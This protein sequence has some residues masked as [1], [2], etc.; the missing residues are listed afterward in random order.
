MPP[1]AK[2][3]RASPGKSPK[4]ASKPG[5][6]SH[7]AHGHDN[8][9]V[10]AE[11]VDVSRSTPMHSQAEMSRK[12]S[13]IDCSVS[14]IKTAILSEDPEWKFNTTFW[15]TILCGHPAHEFRVLQNQTLAFW[16][17]K[18][19]KWQEMGQWNPALVPAC[20]DGKGIG[21]LLG[22]QNN[23]ISDFL[24]LF[25]PEA[26]KR[27]RQ[28]GDTENNR[29]YAQVNVAEVMITGV[30]LSRLIPSRHKLRYAFGVVDL[31]DDRTLDVEQFAAFIR[32]FIRGLGAAF[33][34]AG[35]ADV[36]P[37]EASIVTIANRLY[38]RISLIAAEKLKDLH[39][40][41]DANTKAQLADAIRAQQA[42][43]DSGK[44]PKNGGKSG[45]PRRQLLKFGTLQDWCFRVYKDPLALPYA[46]AI[47]RFCP[48]RYG[49]IL[50]GT[51][52]CDSLADWYLSHKEPVVEPREYAA[53]TEIGQTL[54]RSDVII[55]REVFRYCSFRGRFALCRGDVERHIDTSMTDSLWDSIEAGLKQVAEDM[56]SCVKPEF[57]DFLRKLSPSADSRHLRMFEVWCQQYDDLAVKEKLVKAAQNAAD[58]FLENDLKPVWPE[59]EVHQAHVL[60]EAVDRSGNGIVSAD[61]IEKGLGVDR[62]TVEEMMADYDYSEDGLMDKVEF[63]RM[64]CPSHFRLPEM[65]EGKADRQILGKLLIVAME[66]EKQEFSTSQGKF[67]SS[68]DEELNLGCGMSR[69]LSDKP[70][71]V[72]PEVDDATWSAWNNMF[73]H[74]DKNHDD[75]LHIRE[76]ESSGIVSMTVC[77]F[78]VESLDP[79]NNEGFTRDTLLQA[80]LQAHDLRR[81]GFSEGSLAGAV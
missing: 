73:D 22:L 45:A 1:K 37:S 51:A 60:F 42:R 55:A 20:L 66:R 75:V 30:M 67:R 59:Q 2:S 10:R 38:N 78:L 6:A 40:R 31:D 7:A 56:R 18:Y 14:Q 69:L 62:A 49:E 34:V 77:K 44:T 48:E 11:N 43:T 28:T 71:A 4:N 65:E 12:F 17:K 13:F 8:T 80:L 21:Q 46:L 33:G 57:F 61:D 72:L 68:V 16:V 63:I 27:I 26:Y 47:E 3:A 81:H 24:K 35:N 36:L 15:H 23:R 64:M 25:D 19:N 53:G 74:L 32:T 39:K 70:D 52:E 41:G 54:T 76:I 5:D 50:D 29:R 79:Q 9:H 58:T